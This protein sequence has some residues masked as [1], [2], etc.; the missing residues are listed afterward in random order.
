M[1]SLKK[2]ST[3]RDM[4]PD[5]EMFTKKGATYARWRDRNGKTQTGRVNSAGRVVVESAT[6]YARI[7]KANGARV[8]LPTGC[9]DKSA[10][11]SRMAQFVREVEQIKGGII[12]EQETSLAKEMGANVTTAITAYKAHMKALGMSKSH[13]YNVNMY[14]TASVKEMGWRTLRSLSGSELSAWLDMRAITPDARRKLMGA[15]THNKVIIAWSC[16]ADWLVKDKRIPCNPFTGLSKR[17]AHS[18]RKH[19]RRMLTDEELVKLFAAAQ[20]RPMN[21]ALK[22]NKGRGKAQKNAKAK[23][24][25]TTKDRL[26]W[27]G[28]VRSI[29]YRVAASTGLRLKELRSIR[30]GDAVLDGATPHML[31]RSENEKNRQGSTIPVP[32]SLRPMLAEFAKERIQRLAS[33]RDMLP[34]AF[35][36]DRLFPIPAKMCDVIADDYRAAGIDPVDASGRCVDFHVLRSVFATRLAQAGTP[37]H[38]AQKLL[39]HSDPKLT[40]NIYTHTRLEDM[41]VAVNS[42][43]DFPALIAE[44]CKIAAECGN[45]VAPTVAPTDCVSGQKY[46][47]YGRSIPKRHE[48]GTN[49]EECVMTADSGGIQ[50]MAEER[51]GAPSGVR[52]H[53]LLLRRQALYPAELWAR[54][55]CQF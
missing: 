40:L 6:W 38:V 3:T 35:A 20:S 32:A 14:L 12:T 37:V 45:S 42:L 17:D 9:R 39:R 18:D 27:L 44:K 36:L 52:T 46:A 33:G 11:A 31:L 43:P 25:D 10:A 50:N 4:P 8:D 54:I 47:D 28:R 7:T 49:G 13:E 2:K 15:V 51:N 48:W 53:D 26:F 22:G 19:V 29:A 55:E 41:A 1:A 34:G 24:S 21:E 5:A 30:L 23:L 16:F